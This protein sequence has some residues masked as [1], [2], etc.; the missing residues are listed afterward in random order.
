MTAIARPQ[1]ATITVPGRSRPGREIFRTA[2]S[3]ALIGAIFGLALPH[4][5]S[6]RGVWASMYAMTWAQ[7]LPVAALMIL[8]TA[9]ARA[10][11]VVA[12]AV[13]LALLTAMATRHGLL[14]H[15][16]SFAFRAA[17]RARHGLPGGTPA[18]VFRHPRLM[19]TRPRSHI[20]QKQW[21]AWPGA[22]SR[23]T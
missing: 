12:T 20:H 15:S 10:G 11:M 5:A 13:G 8:A 17:D 19:S 9:P 2:G 21:V 14:M 7:A 4:F 3:V 6:Y 18:G 1:A 23:R 22:L 16:E